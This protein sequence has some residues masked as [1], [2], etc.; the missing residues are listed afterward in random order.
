MDQP[1]TS[2]ICSLAKILWY[3]RHGATSCSAIVFEQTGQSVRVSTTSP[4][5]AFGRVRL[6]MGGLEYLASVE[7]VQVNGQSNEAELALQETRRI[8]ERLPSRGAMQLAPLDRTQGEEIAVKASNY[9]SGG[10]Q[11]VSPQPFAEE[12]LV[13]VTT[14]DIECRGVIRY[15]R[16]AAAG[17][18][19]G[20][21][22]VEPPVISS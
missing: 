6:A 22:L 9:S 19:T 11:V 5:P 10:L 12:L 8:D 20:I 18:L 2:S 17:F 15:C 13:R 4:L 16:R 14:D 7:S 21:E 1:A 3:D